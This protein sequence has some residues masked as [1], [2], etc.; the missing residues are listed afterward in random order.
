VN[1]TQVISTPVGGI[2]IVMV[3]NEAYRVITK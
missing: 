3:G 1:E 2:Y